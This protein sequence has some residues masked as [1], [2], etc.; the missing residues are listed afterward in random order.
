MS[1]VLCEDVR[2]FVSKRNDGRAKYPRQPL[3]CRDACQC[4]VVLDVVVVDLAEYLFDILSFC[5]RIYQHAAWN[6]KPAEVEG[7]KSAP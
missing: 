3:C 2:Q 5:I 7:A 6:D 1:P 4:L